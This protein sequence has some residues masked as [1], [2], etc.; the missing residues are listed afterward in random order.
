MNS[1]HTHRV[2]LYYYFYFYYYKQ[3]CAVLL[4]AGPIRHSTQDNIFKK[5]GGNGFIYDLVL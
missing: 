2:V 1:R 5:K 3:R 4:P